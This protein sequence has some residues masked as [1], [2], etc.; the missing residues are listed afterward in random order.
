MAAEQ[1]DDGHVLMSAEDLAVGIDQSSPEWRMAYWL[2]GEDYAERR[3]LGQVQR[4]AAF[5][6][7]VREHRRGTMRFLALFTVLLL[8]ALATT[9]AMFRVLF[10]VLE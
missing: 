1:T 2:A 6:Q 7:H 8:T 5:R 10:W 9:A 4:R 3:R